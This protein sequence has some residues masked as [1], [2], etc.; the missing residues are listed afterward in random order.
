MRISSGVSPI[1]LV[2]GKSEICGAPAAG[3]L[4]RKTLDSFNIVE[5]L[6]MALPGGLCNSEPLTSLNGNGPNPHATP[7]NTQLTLKGH[8]TVIGSVL[9]GYNRRFHETRR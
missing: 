5:Q 7:D 9:Y 4:N 1:G 3:S 8:W 6:F 2:S